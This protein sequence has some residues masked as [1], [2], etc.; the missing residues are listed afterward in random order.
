MKNWKQSHNTFSRCFILVILFFLILLTTACISD[1]LICWMNPDNCEPILPP[2]QN[3]P[4]SPVVEFYAGT[5]IA[6]TTYEYSNVPTVKTNLCHDEIS[7]AWVKIYHTQTIPENVGITQKLTND[8]YYF[9]AEIH[10][11]LRSP[12]RD[13]KCVYAESKDEYELFQ[14]NG[15]YDKVT[16]EFTPIYYNYAAC[17]NAAKLAFVGN[18]NVSLTYDCITGPTTV[19]FSFDL[20]LQNSFQ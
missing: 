11:A 4:G 5:G 3:T 6:E 13:K 9:T 8:Q 1:D 7:D 18:T 14:V 12:W 2:T 15:I 16:F 17:P 19:H 20:P 10:S